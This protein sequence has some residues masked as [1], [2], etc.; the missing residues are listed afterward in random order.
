MDQTY[1]KTFSGPLDV[2]LKLI[3][4]KKMDIT[5]LSI[6]SVTTDFIHHISVLKENE[7]NI[8]SRLLA[9]FLSVAA[10]LLALK[11]KALLPSLSID[12]EEE[13]FDLEHRLKVYKAY[14]DLFSLLEKTWKE[15]SRLY[16]REFLSSQEPIFY[17]PPNLATTDLFTSLQKVMGA[18][19][20][21]FQE[22]QEVKK[23]VISLESKVEELSQTLLSHRSFLFSSLSSKKKKDEVVVLFLA[24]LHIL[25]DRP[26]FVEQKDIFGE[27]EIRNEES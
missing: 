24:L 8:S 18:A 27:I 7:E 15:S 1:N 3:E 23:Q 19:S 25:R 21:F 12:E 20:S 4:S 2:L 14:T 26:F 22:T 6:A 17:P 11:S 10:H 13:L 5:T 16:A 9:D